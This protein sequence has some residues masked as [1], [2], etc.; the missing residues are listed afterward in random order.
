MFGAQDVA[1]EVVWTMRWNGKCLAI[2]FVDSCADLPSLLLLTGLVRT[3]SVRLDVATNVTYHICF[4]HHQ[5]IKIFAIE[6]TKSY[7]F[8]TAR[9][10][11]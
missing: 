10:Y 1:M 9:L 3:S 5:T 7:R 6:Q 11:Q 2:C 4:L 8:G